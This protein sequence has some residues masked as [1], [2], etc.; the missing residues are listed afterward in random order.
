MNSSALRVSLFFPLLMSLSG[1]G[2]SSFHSPVIDVLG[3]YFPA[4]IVCI[5]SGLTLT[6]ITRLLLIGLKFNTWLYPAPIVY[7]CLM[8]LFTMA[9]WLLFYKN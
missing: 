8:I 6:L 4:W 2:A 1:C 7:P 3:S 9:V 5:V